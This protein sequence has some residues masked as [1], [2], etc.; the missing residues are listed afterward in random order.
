[1]AS[2]FTIAFEGEGR[3][4][5]PVTWG[6]R[7]IWKVFEREGRS[8]NLTGRVALPPGITVERMAGDL[9]HVMSRHQALR[10]RF[11]FGDDGAPAEQVLADRGEAALA[12]VDIDDEDP[13]SAVETQFAL[14][15]LTD[16]D[17]AAD[18]PVRMTVL[19][20]RGELTHF[21][22]A[23]N[24][25]ALDLFG[26][27]IVLADL[28]ER[29]P[30]TGRPAGAPADSLQPAE[31]AHWQST[32][33]ARRQTA[34]SMRHWERLL[35][36]VPPQRLPHRP[37]VPEPRYRKII[38]DSPAAGQ[39][40]WTLAERLRA[41]S[42]AVLLAA[43]AL[44]LAEVAGTDPIVLQLVVNNRF[45]RGMQ[46]IVSPIS[47]H[48]LCAIDTDGRAF[49]DVVAAAWRSQIQACMYAYYDPRALNEL[50]G[51][52][53]AERGAHVDTACYFND[54]RRASRLQP[55]PALAG[56]DG[57]LDPDERAELE[58]ALERTA[59]VWEALSRP[60]DRLAIHI[61]DAPDTLRFLICA[62][63]HYLSAPDM[64]ACARALERILVG[65]AL[66]RGAQPAQAG[67]R[68]AVAVPGTT[69]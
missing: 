39:A 9:R 12:I 37:D 20:R 44:A 2:L 34:A 40:L 62:D 59:V 28:A 69:P 22:V 25:L 24:H 26:L 50:T 32:A 61:D 68:I 8:I 46:E 6:Q 65:H 14:N 38:Y 42:G 43:W 31:L 29:G 58:R 17:S 48:G 13:A 18:W 1:M 19:R 4:V 54:R 10:T 57:Q 67:R 66:G 23:Y 27:D 16:F 21:L 53:D 60:D 33:A 7:E 45:R 30:A 41:E 55:P 51:T 5:A 56:R 3:A 63:T 11:R 49:E 35:R 36:A 64:E 52:V 47:Q 15:D